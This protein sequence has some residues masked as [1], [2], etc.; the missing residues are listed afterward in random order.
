MRQ[1]K[2][3]ELLWTDMQDKPHKLVVPCG[4]ALDFARV[5]ARQYGGCVVCGRYGV[6]A[7]R[8]DGTLEVYWNA[9]S[10]LPGKT[11]QYDERTTVCL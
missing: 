8:N 6:A 2:R 5:V 7:V 1:R 9:A 4:L 11:E 3:Y 10:T